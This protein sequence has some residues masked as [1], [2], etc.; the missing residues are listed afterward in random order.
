MVKV[1]FGLLAYLEADDYRVLVALEMALRNHQVAPTVLIER[2]ARLPRGGARKRLLNLLK[3]KVLHHE[4]QPY[5]GYELKYQAYDFLAFRTFASRDTVTGVGSRIGCGKESDILLVQDAQGN[6]HVVKLQR[7]GRCSFRTVAKNRDYKDGKKRRGASWFYLSR[8]AAM[9]EFAFMKMLYDEGFPVPRPIDHNRH[10]IVMELVPG[11]LLQNIY[12]FEPAIQA[13]K[14]YERCLN[15]MVRMA[16]SGLVHGDFNEFNIMVTDDFRVV[17]IDFPQMVSTDHLNAGDLF[18]RDVVNLA[19]FFVRRYRIAKTLFPTLENDVVRK[20]RLDQK[21]LASGAFTKQQMKELEQM[22]KAEQ[23]AAAEAADDDDE[24]GEEDEEDEEEAAGAA[25]GAGGFIALTATEGAPVSQQQPQGLEDDED[26]E[27]VEPES[28]VDPTAAAPATG[29]LSKALL[30]ANAADD[31]DAEVKPGGIKPSPATGRVGN[32]PSVSIA[33]TARRLL[34]QT[35]SVNPNLMQAG[36]DIN[37]GYVWERIKKQEKNKDDHAFLRMAHRNTLKNK[38]KR[39]NESQ[40]RGA[41][42]ADGDY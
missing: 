15:L 20:S 5:D 18:D 19:E 1:D 33:S 39:G 42:S 11:T 25:D 10:A 28:H 14:V 38:E 17:M 30:A 7:L 16:E 36:G 6:Q 2:I 13:Q 32:A 41:T 24:E 26:A 8:L 27:S 22:L 12:A 34:R 35:S 4:S 31:D 21:V 9:K 37:K 3:F 23:K 40:C 29:P